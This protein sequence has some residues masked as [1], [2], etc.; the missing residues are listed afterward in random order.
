M[1]LTTE[2]DERLV[3]ARM[4]MMG[5]LSSQQTMVKGTSEVAKQSIAYADALLLEHRKTLDAVE[6][7][8]STS[9]NIDYTAALEEELM[10]FFETGPLNLLS[11]FSLS[12]LATRLNS[13][14]KA[15][16]NCA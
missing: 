3:T 5:I 16:Q 10:D 15:Q 1:I 2:S 8:H 7:A 12:D 13:V 4:A 9:S 14:V 6:L 11:N